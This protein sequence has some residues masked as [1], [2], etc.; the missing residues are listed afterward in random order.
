MKDISQTITKRIIIFASIFCLVAVFPFTVN[1]VG[2]A[3]TS[4]GATQGAIINNES[5]G[6]TTVLFENIDH[7][8]AGN[9]YQTVT[10]LMLDTNYRDSSNIPDKAIITTETVLSAYVGSVYQ[11]A[12]TSE[13][14]TNKTADQSQL[15]SQLS[16]GSGLTDD[17]TSS[18]SVSVADIDN[19]GD[20]DLLFSEYSMDKKSRLYTNDGNGYFVNSDLLSDFLENQVVVN[21]L[22]DY[23]NDG[24]LDIINGTNKNK[25]DRVL[26]NNGNTSFSEID[27]VFDGTGYTHGIAFADVD[28]DGYA[29]MFVSDYMPT[30]NNFL[31]INDNGLHFNVVKRAE[32]SQANY[33]LGASFADYDNDGDADL[34]VPNDKMNANYLYENDGTGKMDLLDVAPFNEDLASSTGSSWGDYDNDGDLDLFVTNA[35]K[36]N[37][38]LYNNSGDGQFEKVTSGDLVSDGGDSHGSVWAD[39]DNDGDLDLLVTNDQDQVNFLYMNQGDGTFVKDPQQSVCAKNGNS[40]ATAVGDLN[41]DGFL[42]VVIST[43]SDEPNQVFF[44]NGNENHWIAIKLKGT[45]SN[46]QAIGAKVKVKTKVKGK[47]IWQM[48]EVTSNTGG[49]ANAQ[50]SFT[51]H[52]GL[53]TLRKVDEVLIEWPSGYIQVLS[54]PDIDE[55]HSVTEEDGAMVSGIVFLD[56][57]ENCNFDDGEERLA[58]TRIRIESKDV[59]RYSYTNDEGQY[60]IHV[61]PDKYTLDMVSEN[62]LVSCNDF[63][64]LEVKIKK[65][66]DDI[67][68]LDFGVIARKY[69]PDLSVDVSTTAFRR[70]FDK[71]TFISITN[72]GTANARSVSVK[73]DLHENIEAQSSSVAWDKYANN[74]I[75]WKLDELP[76]NT[77]T[78]II[79]NEVVSLKAAMHDELTMNCSVSS[80]EA[81][82][83]FSDNSV[84]F[85]DSV[86]GAIDPNDLLV[87]P[88]GR[89]LAG[90]TLEYTIRF[91]NV[92]NYP[93]T[94]VKVFNTL[95]D[96]VDKS[97]FKMVSASHHYELI[98][99]EGGQKEWFFGN[100]QLLDSLTNEPESHGYVKY[101]VDVDDGLT[102]AVTLYN[103]ADIIFDYNEAI[104]TNTTITP[105]LFFPEGEDS[106]DVHIYPNPATD[107]VNVTIGANRAYIPVQHVEILSLLG[108]KVYSGD[109]SEFTLEVGV[110]LN[111]P[112]G[113]YYLKAT[114]TDDRVYTTTVVIRL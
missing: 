18:W 79:L 101:Q 57:N 49:G 104:A 3:S 5:N 27:G 21:A 97:S 47:T 105:V 83:D 71:N 65:R 106:N 85:M 4:G 12:T 44:N 77:D 91:Q 32:I 39:F 25:Q 58:N 56:A 11:Q 73:L 88:N 78:M 93:A 102:S 34:F 109:F 40:F 23:N 30:G 60:N 84:L 68:G 69:Q 75:Y 8:E 26:R 13:G 42:D 80:V 10:T 62:W 36:Q 112:P 66:G 98:E 48:R 16:Q 29:D 92:G 86:V 43:H 89:V 41:K 31:Y 103:S 1:A 55:E 24:N 95:P 51:C 110:E 28:L 111:L 108:T 72:D 6:Q 7:F 9:E 15:F 14:I 64:G 2:E 46:S 38:A 17:L 107:Y 63:D 45:N 74:T 20:E 96:Y 90:T 87:S 70:G 50:S 37:N 81:D 22:T 114:G 19:D 35:G 52:F 99:S 94:F 54:K 67:E 100:I 53:G 113:I 33:S 59:T 76:M 61:V 82:L